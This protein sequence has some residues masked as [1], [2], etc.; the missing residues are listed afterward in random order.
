MVYKLVTPNHRAQKLFDKSIVIF[1]NKNEKNF[2]NYLCFERT[3]FLEMT[4]NWMGFRIS[5]RVS[6]GYEIKLKKFLI[7]IISQRRGKF[8]FTSKSP[9]ILQ[10]N[11]EKSRFVSDF[12][13][14]YTKKDWLILKNCWPL[15]M[16][17][18][19]VKL[20]ILAN[21]PT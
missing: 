15:F 10:K 7:T 12:Y 11:D 14:F 18:R 6:F 4:I 9:L 3:L 8:S 2:W 21:F 16:V 13:P 5:F 1:E 17:F 20:N 19:R